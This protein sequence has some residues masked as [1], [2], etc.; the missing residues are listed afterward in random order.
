M[1][2][3]KSAFEFHSFSL[4]IFPRNKYTVQYGSLNLLFFL[5][6]TLFMQN[7][8]PAADR[9]LTDDSLVADR[10]QTDDSLVADRNN[11]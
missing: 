4:N 11:R 2:F 1:S 6:N 8:S 5:L 7:D 3:R 9:Q 10:Q